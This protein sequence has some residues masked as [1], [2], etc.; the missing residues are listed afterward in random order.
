MQIFKPPRLLPGDT[1]SVVS[2]AW[3]GAGLLPHRVALGKDQV[4]RMGYRLKLSEHALDHDSW[5]S[6]SP[7]R[8]AADIQAAFTDPEVKAVIAAIGGD[9]ANQ[10]LPRLD[11]DMLRAHPKIFMGY[12]DITVLNMAIWKTAGMVTF[13]GPAFLTDFAEYPHMFAYTRAYFERAV[14]SDQPVGLVKASQEWTEEFLDWGQQLDL[15]RPRRMQPADG[16]VWLKLGHAEG[17][18]LGGCLESLD[19]LRGTTYWPDDAQWQGAL[20]FIE[21][22]DE[23]PPPARV[24]SILMDYENMGVFDRIGGLLVGRP[25]RYSPEQKAQLH[26]VLL[27]RTAQYHFPIVAEMDFGHTA[28]QITLPIGCRACIDSQSQT[29]SILE[30]GVE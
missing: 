8:R 9:H 22:S 27:D 1:I 21:T 12:S 4:E 28:P 3:G 25:M 29:F 14:C 18:L 30:A 23:V 19:H 7:E 11:F 24:D 5:V 13:N 15:T 17:I 2:P 26:E 16:W 10:L 20:L 6:A